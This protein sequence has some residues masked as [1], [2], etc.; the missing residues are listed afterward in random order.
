MM[1]AFGAALVGAALLAGS[2]GLT[3]QSKTVSAHERLDVL[4]RA[5]VWT[6]TDVPSMDLR[7]GPEEH[8]F[9]PGE[10]VNCTYVDK[11]YGG[12]TPK[13]GCARDSKPKDVMK[14]RYGADNGEVYAGVAPPAF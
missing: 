6:K 13:F 12:R 1:K 4:K 11:K 3:A 9:R 2:I 7:V 14:V 10:T 8:G 5:Q